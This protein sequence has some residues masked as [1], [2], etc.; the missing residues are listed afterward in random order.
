MRSPLPSF[1]GAAAWVNGALNPSTLQG[2]PVLVH[3]WSL[4]CYMCHDVAGQVAEWRERYTPRGLAIVSVHQPRSPEELDLAKVSEDARGPMN[5]TQPCAID[6]DHTIVDRFENQFVPAYYLFNRE[7]Q[8]RHFQ[9]G[10]KGYD[11]IEA[12]VERLLADSDS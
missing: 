10:D 4:S 12:V 6:N 2:K 9:A 1:E 3:F 11:R 5:I 8:L 7:H